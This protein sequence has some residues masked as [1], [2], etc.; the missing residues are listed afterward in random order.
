MCRPGC[1]IDLATGA[2]CMLAFVI[3]LKMVL[4]GY[5]DSDLQSH[6]HLPL[7]ERIMKLKQCAGPTG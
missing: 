4:E 6:N 2:H 7:E 3:L 1:Q 5:K